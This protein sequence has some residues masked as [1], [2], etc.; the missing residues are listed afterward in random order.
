MLP[1]TSN[2]WPS[3]RFP[4]SRKRTESRSRGTVPG[5]ESTRTKLKV[6]ISLLSDI[7]VSLKLTQL[8]DNGEDFAQLN[9]F[10]FGHGD[11]KVLNRW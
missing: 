6:K 8:F 2:T 5:S 1:R 9:A 3:G 7:L 11:L 10:L 4:F